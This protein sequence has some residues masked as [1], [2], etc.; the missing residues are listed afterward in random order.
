MGGSTNLVICGMDKDRYDEKRD[1][2]RRSIGGGERREK[3]PSL[4][5]WQVLRW[6]RVDTVLL[7][8]RLV[9]FTRVWSDWAH[10]SGTNIYSAPLLT[11]LPRFAS[12][13]LVSAL[14]SLLSLLLLSRPFG[15]SLFYSL[16]SSHSHRCAYRK[17]EQRDFFVSRNFSASLSSS[18][19]WRCLPSSFAF[20]IASTL[21]I[22]TGQGNSIHMTTLFADSFRFVHWTA[23]EY[24]KHLGLTF[25]ERCSRPFKND[26][27]FG[28]S[29]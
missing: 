14:C 12:P 17:Q 3:G 4:P 9:D 25:P 18:A 7:S 6:S 16:L 2:K 27:W 1:G 13:A 11:S 22:D 28:M 26:I 5:C 19:S 21:R 8:L 10:R 20:T 15:L 29:Y 24:A 23:C